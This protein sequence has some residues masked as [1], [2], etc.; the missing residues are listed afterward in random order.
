MAFQ[1][2]VLKL[3]LI[4]FSIALLLT[5]IMVLSSKS[6]LGFFGNF[7]FLI[8]V[9]FFT[10]IGVVIGDTFC[11]FTKPDIF[12]S[13]GAGDTFKQKI[14]WMVGP[15]SIGWFIGYMATTGF[16]KNALGYNLI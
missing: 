12:L 14:F 5:V 6:H 8:A 9:S 13:S 1:D 15:Q 10:T 2:R 7:A 3:F 4:C 11:R 16:M